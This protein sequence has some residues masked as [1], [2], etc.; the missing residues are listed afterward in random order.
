M[1]RAPTLRLFLFSTAEEFD[2]ALPSTAKRPGELAAALPE[3]QPRLDDTLL[4]LEGAPDPLVMSPFGRLEMIGPQLEEAAERLAAGQR[5]LLRSASDAAGVFLALEPVG[6][7]GEI[8]EVAQL[9]QLPEPWGSYFPLERSFF[10]PGSAVDQRAALYDYVDAHR[11]ELTPRR[12]Q[13]GQSL[14]RLRGLRWDRD[15]TIAS[16]RH[17]AAGARALL[18]SLTAR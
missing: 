2:D 10:H 13:D 12:A 9:A 14:D 7:E 16:L 1:T 18:T 5:A 15:A 6:S 11:E 8:V 4:W 17:E 3:W